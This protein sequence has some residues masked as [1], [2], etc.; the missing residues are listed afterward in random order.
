MRKCQGISLL[1]AG[2]IF[3]ALE[4]LFLSLEIEVVFSFPSLP[5]PHLN[6]QL[7]VKKK[8]QK[9]KIHIA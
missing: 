7:G 8:V 6:S 9:N 4:K 1:F 3:L 5:K 2:E